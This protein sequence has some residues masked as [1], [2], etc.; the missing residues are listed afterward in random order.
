M[1]SGVGCQTVFEDE[2]ECEY[3]DDIVFCSFY[4]SSSSS[5]YSGIVQ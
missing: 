4:S 2:Y 5:S 1:V 3:E